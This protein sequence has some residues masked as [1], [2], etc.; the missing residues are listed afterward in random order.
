MVAV[1][2]LLCAPRIG[3]RVDSG[4]FGTEFDG[5]AEVEFKSGL[6]EEELGGGEV[7]E[8]ALVEFFNGAIGSG[9]S[10]FRLRGDAARAAGSTGRVTI[11]SLANPETFEQAV[12]ESLGTSRWLFLLHLH[13]LLLLLLLLRKKLLVVRVVARHAAVPGKSIGDVGQAAATSAM[14]RRGRNEA[15]E[16]EAGAGTC[17]VGVVCWRGGGREREGGFGVVHGF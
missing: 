16:C 6:G 9:R 17:W 10:S 7:V 4:G 15:S 5:D 2:W 12:A 14:R 1:R 13:L 3:T 8:G 11:A